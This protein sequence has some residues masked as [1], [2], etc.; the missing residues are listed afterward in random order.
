MA[1][2]RKKKSRNT[3]AVAQSPMGSRTRRISIGIDSAENGNVISLSS[4]GI[5]KKGGYESKTL[6][7]PD[8]DAAIKIATSHIQSMAPKLKKG[9]EKKKAHKKVIS[10]R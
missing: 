8:T 6:I 5:G 7:A 1:R 10:K 4:D 2:K 9:K 3:D